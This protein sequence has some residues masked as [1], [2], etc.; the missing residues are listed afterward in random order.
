V[1]D[2]SKRFGGVRAVDG[3]S[4]TVLPGQ[5]VGII[6]PNGSGK[7]TLFNL[8]GGALRPDSG[9]IFL[10]GEATTGWPA[11]RIAERG[12]ARTFQNGRVFGNMTVGENVRLGGWRRL[13][14]ARPWPRLRHLPLARWLPLAAELA[15]ALVQPP[16]VRQEAR[17]REAAVDRQL[18]R[19]GERLLPRRSSPPSRSPTPTGGGPRSP[20]PW[21]RSRACCCST[22]RRRG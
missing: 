6:G 2:L 17:A 5:T 4:L 18:G 8:I 7:T 19:F 9:Q 11:E 13:E 15:L 16:A 21:R 12:L 22:S 10:A 3:V 14:A 1:R 20:A